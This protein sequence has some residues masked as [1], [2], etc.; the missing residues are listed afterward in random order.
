LKDVR[1]S[2]QTLVHSSEHKFRVQPTDD[3]ISLIISK[4]KYTRKLGTEQ[5]LL[6]KPKNNQQL[7]SAVENLKLA[8]RGFI[9]G[10]FSSIILNTRNAL[11]N[12]LLL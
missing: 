2:P 9:E 8:A 5:S 6:D 3:E 7:T 11:I 4:N 10:N 12:S 1:R